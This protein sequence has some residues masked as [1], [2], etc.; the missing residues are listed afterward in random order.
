MLAGAEL[1]CWPL[2]E[3]WPGTGLLAARITCASGLCQPYQ[4]PIHCHI[5][6]GRQ[7]DPAKACKALIASEQ[8]AVVSLHHCLVDLTPVPG[9]K[10]SKLAAVLLPNFVL[11]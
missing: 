10:G 9:L 1:L 4:N 2:P 5:G 7:K 6:V 3:A 11:K 8:L